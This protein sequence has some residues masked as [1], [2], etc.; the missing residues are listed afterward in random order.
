VTAIALQPRDVVL[1]PLPF[2]ELTDRKL[3]PVVVM[4]AAGRGDWVLCQI[5][6]KSYRLYAA[7]R[8][9]FAGLTGAAHP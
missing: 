4:A 1:M 8:V 3:R 7:S 2:S 6:C 5:T 9:R